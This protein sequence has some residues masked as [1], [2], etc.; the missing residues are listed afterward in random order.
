MKSVIKRGFELYERETG[1]SSCKVT[2]PEQLRPLGLSRRES[3]IAFWAHEGES[4]KAIGERLGL[5]PRTVEK[6]ME[7]VFKKLGIN[8]RVKLLREFHG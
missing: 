5:S 4:N 3:E 7:S 6:H 2:A 1:T 8:S